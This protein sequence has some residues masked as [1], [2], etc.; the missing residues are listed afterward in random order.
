VVKALAGLPK[1]AQT[2]LLKFLVR[3]GPLDEITGDGLVKFVLEFGASRGTREASRDALKAA[4]A[5]VSMA[6]GNDF[7]IDTLRTIAEAPADFHGPL[8]RLLAA[9][10]PVGKMNGELLVLEVWNRAND[11]W[12]RSL[13]PREV[14]RITYVIS[15][16]PAF[17]D[18]LLRFFDD[19]RMNGVSTMM[20]E[21]QARL[22]GQASVD[23]DDGLPPCR[24]GAVSPPDR[25]AAA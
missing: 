16:G 24:E 4:A 23:V 13:G 25:P 22:D 20:N 21:V 12:T 1:N 17:D 19:R 8:L 11:H 3:L 2:S 14:D 18:V 15:L 5:S 9:T 10:R 6:G 7:D